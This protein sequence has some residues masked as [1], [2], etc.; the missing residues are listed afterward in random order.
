MSRQQGGIIFRL[1]ALLAI[2]GFVGILYLAWH[3]LMRAAAGFWIV[4]DRIEPADIMIVI[5]DD[6]YDA[7]RAKEAAALFHAGWAPHIL[8]IGPILRPYA[9]LAH[10]MATDLQSAGVP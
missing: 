9:S 3:P 8:A 5:G 10:H 7:D 4:Q 1:L 2:C 6:N